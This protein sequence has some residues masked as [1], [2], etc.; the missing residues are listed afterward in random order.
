VA[1]ID[2]AQLAQ[3]EQYAAGMTKANTQAT[4]GF[5]SAG[6]TPTT[7]QL[8]PVVA[9]YV[10]AVN[11]YGF[12]LHFIQW[13]AS[14]QNAIAVDIAQ[15]NALKSFAQSFSLVSGTGTSAWLSNLRARAITTQA[16][17][18]QVRRDLGLANSSSF[19]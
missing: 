16:A 2:S 8:T 17:D 5:I 14:M 10:T 11:L 1:P 15:L 19:P 12:Q 18:N 7:A 9:A 6:S 4:N 3:F 13:P